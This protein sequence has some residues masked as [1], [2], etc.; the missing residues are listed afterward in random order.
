MI[1]WLFTGI[2]ALVMRNSR[3]VNEHQARSAWYYI[4][5]N[6]YIL[7]KTQSKRAANKALYRGK[8]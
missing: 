2:I 5:E 1:A 3:R 7:P 4:R 6:P 8:P